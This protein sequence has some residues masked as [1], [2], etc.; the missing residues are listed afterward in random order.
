[1]LAIHHL[2]R[3]LTA[4]LTVIAIVYV[5]AGRSAA[6]AQDPFA[7][8]G[9][10]PA[11][12]P[13]APARGGA[14]G[15]AKTGTPVAPELAKPKPLI[16]QY[17]D[18][19]K[20]TTPEE[21]LNAAVITLNID[22]ADESKKYL[23]AFLAAKPDAAALAE[24]G[25]KLGPAFFLR[26][27]REKEIQPEGEQAALAVL[28]ALSNA[29]RDPARIARLIAELANPDPAQQALTRH[30]LAEGRSDAA[31]ALIAALADAGQSGLHR[32][33]QIALL[34]MKVD[35]EGPLVGSLESDDEGQLTRIIET[36]GAMKSEAAMPRLVRLSV[37]STVGEAV[38]AAAA[39][40]LRRITGKSPR[41]T[42]AERYL[43]ELLDVQLDRA[44]V[45]QPE[46]DE[47]VTV[48]LWNAMEKAPAA[49]ALPVG[50]A[51]LVTAR[52]IAAKLSR[53]VPQNAYYTRLH[54]MTALEADKVL[55][56]LDRPL[57]R[58]DGTA[59][60]MA[61][62]A[63]A[64]MVSDVLAE[65]LARDRVVATVAAA[66]VLGT[67]GDRGALQGRDGKEAPL[68]MA[69]RHSDRRLRITAALAIARIKPRESFAGA[70]RVAETL[71]H[72]AG[73]GGGRRVL[74]GHP[75]GEVGQTLVGY[76]GELGYGA[77]VAP[78]G[79]AIQQVIVENADYEFLLLSDTIATPEVKELVQWLRRDYRTARLP[80]GVMARGENLEVYRDEFAE[81]RLTFVF[82]AV[83]SQEVAAD[84]VRRLER[85][86]GRN[87]IGRDERMDM[88][89]ESLD[90]LSQLVE[91]PSP[92]PSYELIRHE[93][94]IIRAL[95]VAGLSP[96]V[97]RLLG[98]LGTPKA[99][100][101]LIDFASQFG[102]PI[103]DREAAAA[104]FAVA[105][106]RRGI[107]LT[108]DQIRLQ[109]DRYNSSEG[110]DAKAQSVL[111]SILD[112]IESRAVAAAAQKP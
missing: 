82:P 72:F 3:V 109:Y 37:D 69:L 67:L 53:L 92:A 40:A 46:L 66:E 17:L 80:V 26:L 104:A 43:K 28:D 61:A 112:A 101:A 97:A 111:S 63:Q 87:L 24:L 25:Q 99:Q 83:A 100:S 38:R 70:S 23:T 15:A 58:G 12:A 29:T 107:L 93:A 105:V 50:D 60:Q 36:L 20:P 19:H 102:R 78:T 30:D 49:K 39:D 106:K 21:F 74:V 22:R 110:Q 44:K 7:E 89:A 98:L 4:K 51:A 2:S 32:Q 1:M 79:R 86:A 56:G 18:E 94:Q 108:K 8:G 11:V 10:A 33:I 103:A 55:T 41:P 76:V 91:Q 45:L 48:W 64:G 68:A 13:A 27:R 34:E 73:T 31:L 71:A 5:L 54:L 14:S 47:P 9:K 84:L 85:I 95:P 16:L 88:A 35:S 65:S 57:P 75:R 77:E 52:Q 6:M 81:D 42:E 59:A 96:R 90:A 62:A